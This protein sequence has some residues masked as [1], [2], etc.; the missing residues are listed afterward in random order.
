M[1]LNAA[2]N[3]VSYIDAVTLEWMM[4]GMAENKENDLVST[5]V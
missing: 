4:R 3:M 5:K 1:Y 2:K